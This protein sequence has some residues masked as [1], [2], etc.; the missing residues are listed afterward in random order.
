M[1]RPAVDLRGCVIQRKARRRLPDGTR[2]IVDAYREYPRLSRITI[3]R[4]G[5]GHA[6]IWAVDD[7]E[8]PDLR[9]ALR[10]LAGMPIQLGLPL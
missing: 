5:A 8:Q 3:D 9:T 6:V 7:E 1:S 10:R 4:A 2:Q